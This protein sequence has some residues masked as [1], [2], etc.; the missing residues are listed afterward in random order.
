MK[1]RSLPATRGRSRGWWALLALV[2]A[3]Q[4]GA[5]FWLSDRRPLLPRAPR[6]APALH[7][8]ES[9]RAEWAELLELRDPTL[10]ALPRQRGFSALATSEAPSLEASDWSEP[11]FWLEPKPK[12]LG[13]DFLTWPLTNGSLARVTPSMPEPDL[14]IPDV[15]PLRL[16][17][18]SRLIVRCSQPGI[19][20]LT[21]MHLPSWPVRLIGANDAELLTNSV[22]QVLLDVDGKPVSCL[23]L[24][25]SGSGPADEFA[26]DQ[27]R[28]A[29]FEVEPPAPAE[30]ASQGPIL[31]GLHWCALIFDWQTVPAT[32]APASPP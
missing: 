31:A 30:I 16:D 19:R 3:A 2:F 13:M 4:V 25:S 12:N 15:P 23:L 26:L 22:V 6:P 14:L 7:L 5:I 8:L 18:F 32:N 10:F 9:Q 21:P 29:R 11:P 28:T 1:E 20:L 27:A 24:T 17:G